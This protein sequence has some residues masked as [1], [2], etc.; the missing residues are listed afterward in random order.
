MEILK[1]NPEFQNVFKNGKSK[2]NRFFVMYV[3]RTDTSL[4]RIGISVSKKVGNSVVRHHIKRLIK[5]S[6]RLQED[7]FDSGSDIV[8]VV[9]KE[10][11]N[12]TFKETESAIKHLMKLH[13]LLK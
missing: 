4:N 1:K 7:L 10:S 3:I 5:E 11:K 6:F 12:I 2:A 8:I 13:K 9:R